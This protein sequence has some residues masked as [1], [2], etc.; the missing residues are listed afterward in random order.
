[1]SVPK[2]QKGMIQLTQYVHVH[3]QWPGVSINK[4]FNGEGYLNK[5]AA[6]VERDGRKFELRPNPENKRELA[7]FVQPVPRHQRT[8]P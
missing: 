7:L 8:Q 1:M 5:L 6:M 4:V 2:K 3:A